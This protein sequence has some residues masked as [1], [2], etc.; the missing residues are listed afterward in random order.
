[1]LAV[2]GV[3]LTIAI[4]V[5]FLKPFTRMAW[6]RGASARGLILA[7]YG[8]MVTFVAGSPSPRKLCWRSDRAQVRLPSSPSSSRG[9]WQEPR[10]EGPSTARDSMRTAGARSARD[11]THADTNSSRSAA[12]GVK[13][14]RVNRGY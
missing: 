1:V 11:R 2:I 14:A 3:V 9:L 13:E 8:G 5:S 6:K 12:D 4:T 10:P 7:L